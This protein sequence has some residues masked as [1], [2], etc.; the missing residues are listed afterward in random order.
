MPAALN[1][2][3]FCQAIINDGLTRA[4]EHLIIYTC[5]CKH[6]F[7]LSW[8]CHTFMIVVLIMA[9]NCQII[10]FCLAGRFYIWQIWT[11]LRYLPWHFITFST[12]NGFCMSLN[13]LEYLVSLTSLCCFWRRVDICSKSNLYGGK[14]ENTKDRISS[15]GFAS[16]SMRLIN[17]I[18]F[19]SQIVQ[20]LLCNNIQLFSLSI[21]TT[22]IKR[23]L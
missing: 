20:N 16:L 6:L 11:M 22:T 5:Y 8:K 1:N 2:L 14:R 18:Y 17:P 3:L 9:H 12:K 23:T 15:I 19:C 21:D 13:Y 10:F 7:S 4:W